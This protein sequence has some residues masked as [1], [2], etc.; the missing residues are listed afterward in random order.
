[1][2]DIFYPIGTA[3]KMRE[4]Y[5]ANHYFSPYYEGIRVTVTHSSYP[6]VVM[7]DLKN[8]S[9]VPAV[10]RIFELAD[11]IQLGGE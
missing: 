3:L 8:G 2:E 11:P 7:S 9:Y 1:M 10:A 4:E 5:A 6:A